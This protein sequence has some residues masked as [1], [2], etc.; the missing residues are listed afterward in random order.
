[1]VSTSKWIATLETPVSRIH[2][3]RGRCR[4]GVGPV[5]FGER[6]DGQAGSGE[7]SDIV[8][9]GVRLDFRSS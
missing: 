4:C 9:Q 5:G 2:W 8:L 3:I 1:M 6:A 7:R